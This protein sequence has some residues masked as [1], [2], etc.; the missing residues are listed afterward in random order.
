MR[1]MVFLIEEYA[2]KYNNLLLRNNNP[3]IRVRLTLEGY[4]AHRNGV[5]SSDVVTSKTVNGRV[6]IPEFGGWGIM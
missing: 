4:P 5:R 1:K 2:H 3:G 6:F